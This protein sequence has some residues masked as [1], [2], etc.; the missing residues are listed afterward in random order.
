MTAKEKHLLACL[1]LC[2]LYSR[3]NGCT[4]REVCGDRADIFAVVRQDGKVCLQANVYPFHMLRQP[5]TAEGL[6]QCK[7]FVR[8]WAA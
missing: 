4:Y 2:D 7:A 3:N 6:E 1:R 8:R 5:F